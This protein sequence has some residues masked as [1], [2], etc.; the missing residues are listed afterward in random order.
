MCFSDFMEIIAEPLPGLLVLK[1]RVFGDHR[2]YFFES[3]SDA[4]WHQK[5]GKKPHF[6]QDN[7]S[8]SSKGV[9]RGL[10]FQ[11]PPVAQSKLVRVSQGSVFDVAVDLRKNS[12]TYGQWFGETLSEENHLQM[13]IPEGFGHGFLTLEDNTTFQYKCG[14]YYAP[15]TEGAVLWNDPTLN[16][17]WGIS[18]P[19]LSEKDQQAP[20]FTNFESPF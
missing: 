4:F 12:P 11:K 13:Y 7:Q 20:L 14:D 10:H 18:N 19:Q 6:V 16:I 1:P 5:L 17:D 8:K 2:G 3:F 9:L 15:E